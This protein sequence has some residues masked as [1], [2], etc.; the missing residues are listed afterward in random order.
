VTA[1][2]ASST[3]SVLLGDRRHPGTFLPQVEFA[4][5]SGSRDPVAADFNADGRLDIASANEYATFA[6]VLSNDTLFVRPAYAFRRATIGDPAAVDQSSAS[7]ADFDRD[8]R[9]DIATASADALS[10]V[11]LLNGGSAISLAVSG[12]LSSLSVAD[13]NGDGNPDVVYATWG[14]TYLVG[15]YLGD[16]HGGFVKAP[17]GAWIFARSCATGD[18]NRDGKPD[19]VCV[20]FGEPGAYVMQLG[21]GQGDGTF[22]PTTLVVMPDYTSTVALAD[23]NRDGQL[24][25]VVL[26]SGLRRDQPSEVRVF[27][28]DGAGGLAVT[29]WTTVFVTAYGVQFGIVDLNHDGYLDVVGAEFQQMGVALGNAAGFAAPVYTGVATDNVMLGGVSFGDLNVDG[30]VDAAFGSGDVMFGNGNGTFVSGGRFAYGAAVIADF[31]RDG[32]PDIISGANVLANTRDHTNHPP[33]VNAGP[34]HTIPFGPTQYEECPFDVTPTASD[35]DAH[36]L[37]YEWRKDGALLSN[38]PTISLCGP[39]PGRSVYTLT[40]RDGRGGEAT[41]SVTVT[42]EGI[43]EIVLWVADAGTDGRWTHGDDQTAAG[44]FRAYVPNLGAPKVTTPL[45]QPADTVTLRFYADPT[46]TYKLWIRLKA[47]ANS[48]AND[49]VWVQ[50]GGATDLAGTRKYQVGTDSALAVNLEECSGCGVSGWGWEDDGWGAVNR[51]GVL[52]RFPQNPDRDPQ[53]IVIQT[54]EDGVSIDQVVLSAE[55]YLTQRP[56]AAKNDNTI[57]RSTQPPR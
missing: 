15:T 4:A 38:N 14:E 29:T 39:P 2:R 5:G 37:T 54:R 6:T 41:D 46:E 51:N 56:G 47:D 57:L 36:A 43:K 18:M 33:T 11:V 1:N 12:F 34:D 3:V 31:T 28:G 7:L 27:V 20:G 26:V 49:S 48:W 21:L 9:L 45:A 40:V 24:D 35:S 53:G 22:L 17:T 32:L 44:G 8:G 30:N 50:F 23:V 52:L 10:I 13:V 25:A 55:K 42:I 16:G 19:L